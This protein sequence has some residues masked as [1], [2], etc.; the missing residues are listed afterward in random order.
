MRLSADSPLLVGRG[1]HNHLILNDYRISRQH[2]RVTRERDGFVVYDLNSSNGTFVNGVAVR[3]QEIHP[4]DEISFGPH[5]F[6]VEYVGDVAGP[7]AELPRKQD[8]QIAES[9]TSFYQ[10][11]TRPQPN[12]QM[13]T[14]MPPGE[15]ELLRT[16]E[17][18]SL[19]AQR[20]PSSS[21][22]V[23]AISVED[24]GS[25]RE[26]SRYRAEEVK[27]DLFQ[28][29]DAYNK[30]TTLYGFMQS[31]SR[32]IN[33]SELVDLIAR[34]ILDL[35]PA[36]KDVGLYVKDPSGRFALLHFASATGTR[37]AAALTNDTTRA[38]LH[39]GRALFDAHHQDGTTAGSTMFAPMF[40]RDDVFGIIFVGTGAGSR[41]QF[42]LG[43][44][45]MLDGIAVPVGITL[46]NSRMHEESLQRER[47]NRDLE[48][49]AQMQKSFLPREVPS[50]QGIE[51][52][53][54]Y[55][56]A[57]TVGGD[58]YDVFWVGPHHLAVFIG[59]IAGKGIAAALLMAR[60]TGELRVAALAHVEPVPVFTVMNRS[61]IDR[62]Q[63]EV[64]FTAIYFTLDVRTG[65]VR[66][67]AAG[68]P[69]PYICHADGTV[70]VITDGASPAVGMLEDTQFSATRFYLREGDSLVLYTDGVVEA[71]ATDGSL[72]G[73]DRLA[74]CLRTTGSMPQDISDGIVRDVGLF[75]R[76]AP[77]NDDMT[78]FVCHRTTGF[79]TERFRRISD[80]PP[81]T[82]R[83]VTARR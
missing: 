82:P 69:P 54:T 3:R 65:E 48:L 4:N 10:V 75:T 52:L 39:A 68:Q 33:R 20:P 24:D 80:P 19:R 61:V 7:S 78:I 53:A 18:A 81:V 50:V 38:I 5:A 26:S 2:S 9:M 40:D 83:M 45:E 28:L 47:L 46:Q 63:P 76:T 32:T 56:A 77:A 30:L 71:A 29:E 37:A 66:L 23:E 41:A 27:V 51:F 73:D 79:P 49:A 74:Q 12:P 31:I 64:F 6:R 72:Y 25:M 17:V 15:A 11:N 44:L 36:A 21:N 22:A 42:T 62:G 14:I 59:D 60:I 58:F 8:W 13:E 43:D 55:K 57:Y 35:Y 34:Q 16:G 70:E 1:A 67:A